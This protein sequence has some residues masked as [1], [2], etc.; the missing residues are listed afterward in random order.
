M[1][2]NAALQLVVKGIV[3]KNSAFPTGPP[4]FAICVQRACSF[5]SPCLYDPST[6]NLMSSC[7]EPAVYD[8]LINFFSFFF[9]GLSSSLKLPPRGDCL[10][11]AAHK[12]HHVCSS[13]FRKP[14]QWEA[15]SRSSAELAQTLWAFGLWHLPAQRMTR[16]FGRKSLVS[17]CCTC[18]ITH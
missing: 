16:R 7:H 14:C 6:L 13:V 18:P 9:V 1:Y 10:I 15:T 12:C 4:L 17:M 3:S 8:S 11:L 2:T 5:L